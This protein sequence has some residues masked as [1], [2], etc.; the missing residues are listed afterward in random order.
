M[1]FSDIPKLP[2][3]YYSVNTPLRY[4]E[5][6]LENYKKEYGLIMEPDFQRA[7]VWTEY[8]QS[9]YVEW[10]LRG[11]FSGKDIFFNKP[12]WMKFNLKDTP[13]ILVDGLQ[14]L[15]AALKF[16]H[17]EILV[18]GGYRLS[19]F[20]DK[21]PWVDIAFNFHINNLKTRI[22]VLQWYLDF[23]SG[24]TLHTVGELDKVREL[25]KKEK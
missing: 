2:F 9:S 7:H 5:E 14:R 8:Q 23:N 12:D 6:T 11:G 10:I 25:L 4:L 18:F 15:T 16:L 13:L 22:E 21:M 19:D 3:A 1:K 24:G 17:N 20:E